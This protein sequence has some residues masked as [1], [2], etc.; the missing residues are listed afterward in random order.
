MWRLGVAI[1]YPSE[2]P[3]I[4][5]FEPCPVLP[6]KRG[7]ATNPLE[8]LL[9]HCR[10]LFLDWV[11]EMK[12]VALLFNA[13]RMSSA[14]DCRRFAVDPNYHRLLERELCAGVAPRRA[15]RPAIGQAAGE[16]VWRAA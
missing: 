5:R 10:Y 1:S 8:R 2:T 11:S 4:C 16:T 13:M 3:E 15:D 9:L 12:F 14:I 7:F 6:E